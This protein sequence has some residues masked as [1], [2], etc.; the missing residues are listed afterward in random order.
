MRSHAE[1]GSEKQRCIASAGCLAGSHRSTKAPAVQ[2]R[3]AACGRRLLS[4]G[5]REPKRGGWPG[6]SIRAQARYRHSPKRHIV[7]GNPS[8]DTTPPHPVLHSKST[9]FAALPLGA[10]GLYRDRG[11]IPQYLLAFYH[12]YTSVHCV[13]CIKALLKRSPDPSSPHERP[14]KTSASP[15]RESARERGRPRS[16]SPKPKVQVPITT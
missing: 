13:C 1:H 15:G 6:P 10:K 12:T 2:A 3:I 4:P 5:G 8:A 11:T 16:G 7:A 14:R 9:C